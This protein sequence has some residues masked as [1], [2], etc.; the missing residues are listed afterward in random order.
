LARPAR[1][2]ALLVAAFAL[3]PTVAAAL[4]P[5]YRLAWRVDTEAPTSG[6]AVAED[7]ALGVT[8]D[9]VVAVDLAEGRLAWTVARSGGPN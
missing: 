1:A 3:A 6:L 7:L 5:P 4:A 9:A 8:A 2:A